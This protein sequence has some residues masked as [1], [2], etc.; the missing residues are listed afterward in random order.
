MENR[1]IDKSLGIVLGTFD[2]IN[3]KL[4]DSITESCEN[5]KCIGA[6][7]YSNDLIEQIYRK[8]IIKIS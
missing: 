5:H 4:V 3:K 6:G 8:K 2:I 7:V 1:K